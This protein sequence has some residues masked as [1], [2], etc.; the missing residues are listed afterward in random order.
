M[1]KKE[2]GQKE[3]ASMKRRVTRGVLSFLPC[4]KHF[5]EEHG[6]YT[7]AEPSSF[8]V[9]FPDR[10]I[11]Q[12]SRQPLSSLMPLN[13]AYRRAPTAKCLQE[14]GCKISCSCVP[15]T[16]GC[17]RLAECAWGAGQTQF[18]PLMARDMVWASHPETEPGVGKVRRTGVGKLGWRVHSWWA[19]TTELVET[20]A[21]SR[22]SC[23][24]DMD[25]ASNCN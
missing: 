24:L 12:T 19:P 22:R 3:K 14:L 10:G 9:E 6:H 23:R 1:E 11:V 25:K 13:L 18:E 17:A 5:V 21:Q 8:R 4:Q 2:S 20:A 16:G 15:R 7:S